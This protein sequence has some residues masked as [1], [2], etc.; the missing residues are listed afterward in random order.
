VEEG[1]VAGAVELVVIAESDLVVFGGG[2]ETDFV[3]LT[4]GQTATLTVAD[5]HLHLVV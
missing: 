3:P 1:G 5:R 2:I 4:W